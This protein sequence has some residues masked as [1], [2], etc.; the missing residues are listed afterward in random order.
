[1]FYEFAKL[2]CVYRCLIFVSHFYSI[3]QCQR[4]HHGWRSNLCNSHRDV[5]LGDDRWIGGYCDLARILFGTAGNFRVGKCQWQN[6]S[7]PITLPAINGTTTL[8]GV[9]VCRRGSFQLRRLLDMVS[10][11]IHRFGAGQVLRYICTSTIPF[12]NILTFRICLTALRSSIGSSDT[13]PYMTYSTALVG[14]GNNN[15]SR[16]LLK[17]SKDSEFRASLVEI[18]SRLEQPIRLCGESIFSRL[19]FS[20]VWDLGVNHDILLSTDIPMNDS[21]ASMRTALTAPCNVG[22]TH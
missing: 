1:M 19:L 10:N 20:N 11:W 22:N 13:P 18:C 17:L 16:M 3:P 8:I 9:Q 5:F 14:I 2:S 21:I 12:S 7:L 6:G 15:Y 4:I